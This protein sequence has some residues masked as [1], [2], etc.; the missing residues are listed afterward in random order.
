MYLTIPSDAVSGIYNLEVEAYNYDA[1]TIAKKQIT[2]SGIEAE[3]DVEDDV[4]VIDDVDGETRNNTA[5]ILTI[6]LAII[7]I[8]LLI[9]LIVLITKKPSEV[10]EFGEGETNYY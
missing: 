3:D 5:L 8:V 7:F 10:E 4:E 1:S 6:V 9:I 2:L